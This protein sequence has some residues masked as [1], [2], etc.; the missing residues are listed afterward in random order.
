MPRPRKWYPGGYISYMDKRGHVRQRRV[1]FS[2]Q[3]VRACTEENRTLQQGQSGRLSTHQREEC[4][5]FQDILLDSN[6]SD[7]AGVSN[8][9]KKKVSEA[10]GWKDL[11][12]GLVRVHIEGFSPAT[13]KCSFC[14]CTQVPEIIWCPDCGPRSLYCKACDEKI[15]CLVLYHQTYSWKEDASLFAPV[16]RETTILSEHQCDKLYYRQI[17]VF[18]AQGRDHTIKMQ[19]CECEPEAV[20]L[21]R[22]GLW[23]STP[24]KPET[25]FCMKLMEL[26]RMLQLEG[27]MSLQ[28][29]CNAL[30]RRTTFLHSHSRD[31]RNLYKALGNTIIEFHHHQVLCLETA[32]AHELLG[33]KCP[34]C[35]LKPERRVISM[36]ANF[37]LVHKMNSGFGPGLEHAR[38]SV[39]CPD[40]DVRNF[41]NT[42][43]E[44]TSKS[45]SKSSECSNFQAG[46]LV[47]SKNKN[48]KLDI[49]GVFGAVCQHGFPL[50]FVN[51]QHGERFGYPVYILQQIAAEQLCTAS[52]KQI[53]M[54]DV[55]CSLQAHITKHSQLFGQLSEKFRFVVPVFH[56]FA[57]ITQCQ[58]T[59]GQRFCEGTGLIDGEAMERLWSFLRRFAWSKEMTLPNRQDLLSSALLHYA[60]RIFV[61]LAD[62]LSVRL[63]K[64]RDT[65]A[66]AKEII[67]EVES[68]YRGTAAEWLHKL[69]DTISTT[70]GHRESS[71][72]DSL[73]EKARKLSAERQQL[74]GLKRRYAD[75][76]KIAQK[77]AKKLR[78]TNTQ[79]QS[80]IGS[81]KNAFPNISPAEFRDPESALYT[82]IAPE[83]N[84]EQVRAANCAADYDR[85]KEEEQ[86]IIYDICLLQQWLLEQNVLLCQPSDLVSRYECALNHVKSVSKHKVECQLRDLHAKFNEQPGFSKV[87]IDYSVSNRLSSSA[88]TCQPDSDDNEEL[89]DVIRE[90]NSDIESESDEDE[91]EEEE[92]EHFLP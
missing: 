68:K 22:N 6:S 83:L 65:Q 78:T 37:G 18:D 49:R 11:R 24:K 79:L 8:H 31:Y 1:R 89:I 2:S 52:T 28:K 46:D 15:H 10:E 59:K 35:S 77:I 75:G 73:L 25:A 81:L 91:E 41:V 39:F 88:F 86:R 16:L 32:H 87:S 20:T 29:F 36:D 27:Q 85:G 7:V 30:Q 64:A 50:H 19:F 66:K 48:A 21:V 57:H 70:S 43:H 53:V 82:H 44:A 80:V 84:S 14:G 60:R 9:K 72:S 74:L 38:F 3:A 61:S 26:C 62:T 17:T 71:T 51:M 76:Q 54:Y 67:H 34:I 47:R 13:K 23:P 5:T 45:S 4:A 33:K 63:K 56:S 69:K 90:F 55:A 42:H 92:E 12:A 58:M 40:D